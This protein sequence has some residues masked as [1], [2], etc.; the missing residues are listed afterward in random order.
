MTTTALPN[1]NVGHPTN[2]VD[3]G[4]PGVDERTC[5][6]SGCCWDTKVSGVPWCFYRVETTTTYVTT[7]KPAPNCDVGHPSTRADCGYPGISAK[8][9]RQ[10]YCCWDSSYL[11]VPW[12]FYGK[13][14]SEEPELNCYVGHPSKRL[15]CGYPGIQPNAC[16]QRKCCWD[17]SIAGV[18]WCFH[19]VSFTKLVRLFVIKYEI[20]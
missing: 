4:F 3:C 14:S 2:R 9:C 5:R 8:I 17:Q 13:E 20:K 16:R 15:D 1:C 11:G 19:G 18:P 7:Q 12:C 10:R 6:Q